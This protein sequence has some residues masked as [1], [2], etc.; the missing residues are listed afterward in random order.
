[1]NHLDFAFLYQERTPNANVVMIDDNDNRWNVQRLIDDNK[2]SGIPMVPCNMGWI[3]S[4]ELF[5]NILTDEELEEEKIQLR[6]ELDWEANLPD[7]RYC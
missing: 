4:I 7:P 1:M 2:M 3:S 5:G 6:N